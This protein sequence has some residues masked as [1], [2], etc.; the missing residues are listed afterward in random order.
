MVKVKVGIIDVKTVKLRENEIISLLLKEEVEK[1]KSYKKEGDYLLSLGGAYLRKLLTKEGEIFYGEKGKPYKAGEFFNVSHS[2][3]FAV[4]AVSDKEV[5]VDVEKIR[6]IK[7]AVIKRAFSENEKAFILSP[8]DF[9]KGWTLKES[10]LK[11]IGCGLI[12]RLNEV[13]SFPEG[14]TEYFGERFFTKS[15]SLKGHVF[16]VAVK[17][18]EEAETELKIID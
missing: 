8:K 6:D 2:G 3:D 10:L 12:S 14:K 16:S 7:S 4:I 15:F 9:Y 11:C 18:D 17:T 13:P 5:G 1:A